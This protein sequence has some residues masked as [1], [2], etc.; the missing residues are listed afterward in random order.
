MFDFYLAPLILKGREVREN[1]SFQCPL[2]VLVVQ[3][4]HEHL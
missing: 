3:D 4:I 2:V 1:P